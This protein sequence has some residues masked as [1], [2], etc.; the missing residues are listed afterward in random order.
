MD[1]LYEY[2]NNLLSQIDDNHYRFLMNKINW[3]QQM[4]AIKG[5]RG[6][7]K[8]TLM[9]QYL[10]FELARPEESLYVT[11]DH[12]WFYSC[13][14]IETADEFYKNGGRYLFIDEVHKY[15]RWSRELKNIYDGY[16]NLRVV[17]SS[18]SV[19]DIYRGEADLSRRVI[20]YNLPGLSFR[21]YLLF[22]DVVNKL[23]TLSLKDL[24]ENPVSS[25][26]LFL[27]IIGHPLPMFKKYLKS[28]YLPIS[29]QKKEEEIPII[30]NQII[31]TII[32]GDLAFLEG[33]DSG[34][35]FKLKKLL[36]V[37]AESVPFKPNISALARKLNVGR[38]MIY[39]WFTLL[40]KAQLLNLLMTQGKGIS[41][42]QKPDKVYLE[43]PNFA[44]ALKSFP[45]I[46]NLRE[47]FMMNQLNNIGMEIRLPKSG[48]FYLPEFDLYIEVGGKNKTTAQV[49]N[50]EN[51]IVAKD[52]IEI[53]GGKTVPLWMFGM[54]Y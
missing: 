41:L 48:D 8:T 38:E 37:I 54:L 24:L 23:P 53:G 13:N 45:D 43:N 5:P 17:F 28:G 34:T 49:K 16:P 35:A 50:N 42:L 20:S 4:L 15:P 11:A 29:I 31:N 2:S 40:Q 1:V 36:G 7:G 33:Y 6:S 9:L 3:D 21:E 30:L 22:H 10:K 19:L 39:S 44:C 32:E 26:Q 46:G 12:Y 25:T 47:T 27:D 51:F 52:D 18:S 14:L